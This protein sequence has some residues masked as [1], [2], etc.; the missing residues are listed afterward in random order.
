VDVGKFALDQ[1]GSQIQEEDKMSV[2][3]S[4]SQSTSSS[5]SSSSSK[6]KNQS[7]SAT[8]NNELNEGNIC[9]ML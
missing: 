7:Q 2:T 9:K 8:L 1:M 4:Q 3:K 5:S 6:K